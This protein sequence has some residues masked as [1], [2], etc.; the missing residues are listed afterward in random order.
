MRASSKF[1]ALLTMFSA[2]AGCGDDGSDAVPDEPSAAQTEAPR[3]DVTLR[4]KAKVGSEDFACGRSY[5]DQ[6]SA[7]S[8]VTPQDFRFFVS[9]IRLI[10]EDGSEVP[11]AIDERSP[12]QTSALALIDFT[13]QDGRCTSGGA[14]TNLTIT[15][16][17]P[18]GKY[19]G[20][21]FA[22]GVP[23][24]LN[25]AD[26]SVAPAPLQAPGASWNWLLGYRFVMAEVVGSELRPVSP[27][28][29]AGTTTPPAH[30]SMAPA[31]TGGH[32]PAA[33]SMSSSGRGMAHLG[34]TACSGNP[35][36]GFRCQ[37]PNRPHIRLPDFDPSVH[38]I[39]ADF[40]AIFRESDLDAGAECHSGGELCAPMFRALGLDFATGLALPTQSVFHVE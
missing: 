1:A 39:V 2:A 35:A 6:G 23:E 18:A 37:K 25:H 14:G 40:G 15:G 29:A 8:T 16:K 30:G 11:L 21:A 31:P 26:P 17:V 9:E 32:N 34:S 38:T 36:L 13:N 7:K 3:V 5:R 4:F 27:A 22:N 33:G 19:R 12:Y 24:Q 10:A 28:V 20:I